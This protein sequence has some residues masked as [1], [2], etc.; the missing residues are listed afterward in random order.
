[1][2][3]FTLVTLF[4]ITLSAT[5]AQRTLIQGKVLADYENI[6]AAKIISPFLSEQI[7][8]LGESQ[9]NDDGSFELQFVL[10]EEEAKVQI[11]LENGPS[12]SMIARQGQSY[13]FEIQVKEEKI[14]SY[15]KETLI[16]TSDKVYSKQNELNQQL[17]NL[18]K[19]HSKAN[20]ALK[21]S[22]NAA[23]VE[24]F[25]AQF[26]EDKS[27]VVLTSPAFRKYVESLS[28]S[29]KYQ[30]TYQ[31]FMNTFMEQFEFSTRYIDAANNLIYWPILYEAMYSKEGR[32]SSIQDKIDEIGDPRIKSV[33]TLAMLSY[34]IGRKSY[35][36]KIIQSK[37][38]TLQNSNPYPEFEKYI[39]MSAALLN[40]SLIGEEVQNFTFQKLDGSDISIDQ[41]RGEYLLLDFWATWCGPC[42][43]NMKKLP[44]LKNN[45]GSKLNV[46]C[47]TTET[48]HKKVRSFINRTGYD[49]DLIFVTSKEDKPLE[50]YFKKRAIPLYYLIN[51]EGVIVG[52]A[53]TDPTELIQTHLN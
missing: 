43:K 9:I 35:D 4:T 2:R 10:D 38:S 12:F 22:Y 19:E 18:R 13:E 25:T 6:Q 48:N 16:S 47:I 8:F 31:S 23:L 3:L 24:R 30:E 27:V 5:F 29:K 44:A 45:S 52:K 32:L 39:E 41:F 11:S 53:V 46:L 33:L 26:K 7:T 49:K 36:Q 37:L 20:G 21:G 42:V 28:A 14:F 40:E 51:P 15:L 1:M 50:S 34:G 17:T